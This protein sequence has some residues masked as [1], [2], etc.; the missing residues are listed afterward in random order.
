MCVSVFSLITTIG[1]IAKVSTR[2]DDDIVDRIHHRYTALF[3]VIFAVLVSSTQYVGDP[4]HC[5][6]PAYFT[7]NHEAYANKVGNILD[8]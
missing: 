6:C 1:K 7:S 2:N 8:L 4:I 3:L 5:W